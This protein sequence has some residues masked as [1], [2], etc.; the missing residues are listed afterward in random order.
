M[1][2]LFFKQMKLVKVMLFMIGMLF[3]I[4]SYAQDDGTIWKNTIVVSTIDG[5]TFE[6]LI[7]KDTKVRLDNPNLVIETE[8]VILSYELANMG[9][10]RYGR[11][12]ITNGITD[13]P[14]VQP[15]SFDNE[16]LYFERLPQGS[17]IEVFT[18]DGKL[19]SSLRC[20]DS[21]RFS[22]S[23]LSSGTYIVKV[24]ESTYKILKK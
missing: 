14:A 9:Q 13:N 3:T 1:I 4:E 12:P 10:L 18:I 15:F 6:Y 16:T 2:N 7:D 21:A 17:L 11:R 19:T 5:T 8:G 24:N 23:A 22:L 20:G